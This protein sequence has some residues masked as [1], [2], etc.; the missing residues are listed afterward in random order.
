M[1]ST[2]E[3]IHRPAPDADYRQKSRYK[4]TGLVAGLIGLG[5][6]MVAAIATFAA[7]AGLDTDPADAQEILA[8]AFGLTVLGFGFV[9]IGIAVI[10]VGIIY[11]LWF[12]VDSV[13]AALA[14]LKP[15]TPTGE[16]GPATG[17]ISTN[18]GRARVTERAPG[19]LLIHRV[20][21][22][23]WAPMLA[24]GAM[25]LVVG[26]ILSLATGGETAGTT[27]FRQLSAWTQGV[28]FLG[29]GLLLAGISFLL[30]T[31]LY[32]LRTGGGE[33]QESL[34]VSVRTLRMPLTAKLF[35]GIMMLGMMIVM[36]QLALYI[37][38]AVTSADNAQAFAAWSAWLGPFRELGLGTLLVG[39]VLALVTIGNVLGFQFNRVREIIRTGR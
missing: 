2:L 1:T 7:A 8:W 33:V 16:P 6:V 9:K 26:F 19:P 20:A 25:A 18:W 36:T 11:R 23:A 13:K 39:I 29:E 27:D 35:V 21:K 5:A 32:G 30:G 10:L 12:R 3:V 15:A 31:I 34:G 22:I 37:F 28:M 14:R 24:M 38:V 17:E 4:T